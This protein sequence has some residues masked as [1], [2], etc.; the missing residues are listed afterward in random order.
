VCQPVFGENRGAV[1]VR[2]VRRN[3]DEQA[4]IGTDVFFFFFAI[5]LLIELCDLV[6]T[7]DRVSLSHQKRQGHLV[8]GG[9]LT[10]TGTCCSIIS[11]PSIKA[12]IETRHSALALMVEPNTQIRPG[13]RRLASYMG[14]NRF[15]P[16]K[17]FASHSSLQLRR[18]EVRLDRNN[19]YRFRVARGALCNCCCQEAAGKSSLVLRSTGTASAGRA[20]DGVIIERQHPH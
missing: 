6:R 19:L 20:R 16:P 13:Q 11:S 14:V 10:L 15:Y 4:H 18:W 5:P 17:A 9:K 3:A 12:W 8:D 2:S 1:A 7:L